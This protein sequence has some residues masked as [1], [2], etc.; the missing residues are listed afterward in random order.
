MAWLDT[1]QERVNPFECAHMMRIFKLSMLACAGLGFIA[2]MA[3]C[4]TLYE[5]PNEQQVPWSRPA[6][7]EGTVP[8]MPTSPG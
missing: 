4:G 6:S 7:W 8:G 1:C 2:V 5:D 3:G